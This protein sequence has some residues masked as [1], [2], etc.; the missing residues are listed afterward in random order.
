MKAEYHAIIETTYER[1]G[2][3]LFY[4]MHIMPLKLVHL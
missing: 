2:F 4:K 1:C 3:D